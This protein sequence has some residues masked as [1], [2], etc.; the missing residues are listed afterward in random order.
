MAQVQ[1]PNQPPPDSWD[2]ELAA[3]LVGA[4]VL[5]GVTY[6]A[7]D[8]EIL[9]REQFHGYV[10]SAE[11]DRGVVLH[12]EGARAGDTHVLPPTTSVFERASPGHYRLKSTEETV[13]DPDYLAT[14]TAYPRDNA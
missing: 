4:L 7:K 1:D 6:R 12:L 11:R 14:W 8:E 10:I 2:D 13:I 3:G 5:V 9:R